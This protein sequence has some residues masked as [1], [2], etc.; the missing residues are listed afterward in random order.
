MTEQDARDRA[1]HVKALACLA[2]LGV[3]A[4][5]AGAPLRASATLP[6]AARDSPQHYIVLTVRNPVTMPASRAASS[7]RGYDGVG[8]YLAG[9]F[10]R[11]ISRTIA[12]DYR[13]RET[14]TWPIKLLEVH[15]L[16]YEL[17]ADADRVQ[18]L[19]ALARDARVESVQALLD[20]ETAA[21]AYNDPYAKLQRN[22]Q[23]MDV[24][25]AHALSRGAGVRVALIDTGVQLN[26]PD[27][28]VAMLS[29]NFVD[30]D[31]DSFRSDAH[32]TAV[33]GVVAAVPGNGIG[34][35]GIAPDVSLLAYKA[36]WRASMS[37][38]RAVC[39]TFTLAQAIAA[40]V[41]ARAD[42][43]NLSLDGPSDP[44]LTRLIRRALDAGIIV[45]GAVP[46]DGLRDAFPTD[47]AGVIAADAIENPVAIAGASAD[48][49]ILRAPGRDVLSLAPQ[50]HY[51]FYSGSSL[52]TAEVTGIIALL[53]AQRSH[54]TAPEAVALLRA[55]P[56][57]VPNACAA[58]GELLHR[59]DCR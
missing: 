2:A 37:G 28:P 44:L 57:S 40:A 38:I 13:L 50:D 42:I 30:D 5:S 19:A 7:P 26:H 11:A 9:G 55:A 6:A 47:I 4:C 51:D 53:R 56:P 24:V 36:C 45:V 8:P 54:L 14:A 41:E 21:G 22:V 39:N 1:A 52:A 27:L 59:P 29:R 15:C 34:I 35:V 12:K 32:G 49:T 31:A 17:P 23:Q 43:I 10:A 46:P 18:L 3:A 48:D 58:L 25:A 16:V 33:A 20:F